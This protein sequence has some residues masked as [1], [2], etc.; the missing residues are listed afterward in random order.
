MNKMIVYTSIM[1][2]WVVFGNV[3]HGILLARRKGGGRPKTISEHAV[4]SDKLLKIH[5][6]IHSI[7]LIVFLPFIIYYLLPKGYH[8]AAL[9]LILGAVFDSIETLTLNKKTAPLDSSPNAHYITAWLMAFSYLGYSFVIS[10]IAGVSPL[11]YVPVL[12]LCITLAA[13]AHRGILNRISLAMQMI[14][15]I[16]VSSVVLIANIKLILQ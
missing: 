16:L 7:P 11:L 1:S 2:I 10:R 4:E 6:V 13:L 14:Y 8:Y 3:W 5:R 12:L 15:F 9:L